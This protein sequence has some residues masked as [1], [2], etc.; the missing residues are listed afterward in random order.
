MTMSG[1][2]ELLAHPIAS[3][4]VCVCVRLEPAASCMQRVAESADHEKS[5]MPKGHAVS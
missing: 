5:E 1:L 4:G 3:A 2:T